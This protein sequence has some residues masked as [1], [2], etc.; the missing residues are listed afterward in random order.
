M[1]LGKFVLA[2][3]IDILRKGLTE[4]VDVSQSLRDLDVTAFPDGDMYAYSEGTI[5]LSAEYLKSH[6]RLP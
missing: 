1:K 5:E 2:E 6:G 4:G 3:I